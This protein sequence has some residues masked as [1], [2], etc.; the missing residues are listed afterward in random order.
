MADAIDSKKEKRSCCFPQSP[1]FQGQVK[2]YPK[3]Q[4]LPF[5][6]FILSSPKGEGHKSH[7]P[8][9]LSY[10][11][12][13]PVIQNSSADIRALPRTP[14]GSIRKTKACCM[15]PIY[16]SHPAPRRADVQYLPLQK[17]SSLLLQRLRFIISSSQETTQ[18]LI[19][20]EHGLSLP[21]V[22]TGNFNRKRERFQKTP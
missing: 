22:D 20:S 19:S 18:R 17:Q 13:L 10:I 1:I 9:Y 3:E 2:L 4:F 12:L 16:L 6:F 8:K 15:Y 11:S 21:P 14:E 5:I 7:E